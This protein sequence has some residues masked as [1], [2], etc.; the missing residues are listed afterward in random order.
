M[1][2]IA[3]CREFLGEEITNLTDEEV[4]RIRDEMYAV[5]E[6]VTTILEQRRRDSSRESE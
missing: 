6:V 3:K 1:L 5:A 2:S 4:K